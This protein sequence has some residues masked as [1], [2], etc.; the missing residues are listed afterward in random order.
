ME[1]WGDLFRI[2]PNMPSLGLLISDTYENP[3]K[4]QSC[5]QMIV[6]G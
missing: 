5:N 1:I 4:K 3:S 6:K 2:P